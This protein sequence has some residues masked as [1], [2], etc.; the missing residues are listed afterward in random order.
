[1]GQV[2]Q[3]THIRPEQNSFEEP[4]DDLLNNV[5]MPQQG[6]AEAEKNEKEDELKENRMANEYDE[7]IQTI[8]ARTLAADNVNKLE[9]QKVA[10][11]HQMKLKE[12]D[13]KA[14]EFE[15]K[16]KRKKVQEKLKIDLKKHK[17]EFERLKQHQ[18]FKITKQ[19]LSQNVKHRKIKQSETLYLKIKNSQLKN[20]QGSR[21]AKSENLLQQQRPTSGLRNPFEPTFQHHNEAMQEEQLGG[22][23]Q[24]E[25]FPRVT[26]ES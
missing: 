10:G 23:I 6:E 21:K 25:E 11:N 22:D 14:Y 13:Q 18:K 1:M 26:D 16:M 7:R 9:V 24:E 19:E 12:V 4:A 2:V 17:M 8:K 15:I 3:G 5:E 20:Q